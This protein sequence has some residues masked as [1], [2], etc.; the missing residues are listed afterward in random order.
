[1]GIV[2]IKKHSS[3]DWDSSVTCCM[4]HKHEGKCSIPWSIHW[5]KWVLQ[6]IPV[7]TVLGDQRQRVPWACEQ[8]SLADLASSRFSERSWLKKKKKPKHKH[9]EWLRYTLIVNLCPLHT[10]TCPCASAYMH[11]CSC[12]CAHAH[13]NNKCVKMSFYMEG[14]LYLQILSKCSLEVCDSVWTVLMA[15]QES[16]I[17]T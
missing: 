2:L 6:L 9:R 5:K 3:W 14:S 10:R 4:T 16:Q 12:L 11:M 17:G 1:M 13:V 15:K 7:T 8:A